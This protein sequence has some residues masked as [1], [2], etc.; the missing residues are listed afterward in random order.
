MKRSVT[1][2]TAIGLV[3][4]VAC[5]AKT[6]TSTK[7]LVRSTNPVMTPD[8]DE[9]GESQLSR[10]TNKIE[11]TINACCVIPGNAY[12]AWWLIGDVTKPMTAVK[13]MWAAGWVANS[14]QINLQLE[15]EAGGGSVRNIRNT[16]DGVRIV[17]LDHG[18]DSGRSQQ[19]S[20]PEGG[21]GSTLCPVVME[22][23]HPAP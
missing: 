9:V 13:T 20:T 22:V 8:G 5:S 21:C 16:H 7:E 18:P 14:E 15:L 17:V 11:L 1:F 4:L 12:T 3:V 6:A 2:L 23:A 19:L 10:I